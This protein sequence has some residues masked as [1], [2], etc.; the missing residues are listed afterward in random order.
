MKVI[1]VRPAG[2]RPAEGEIFRG[3]VL[4]QTVLGDADT[5]EHRVLEV[6]FTKG[7][8]TKLHRHTT[9]QVLVITDGEGVVGTSDER[10]E[11]SRG[12]VVYIPKGEPHFHGAREGHDMTHLSVLGDNHT[13]ILE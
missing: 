12:D 10:Q 8:R 6:T 5:D 11:V 13:T 2:R 1:R 3:A 9:D 4:T 7:G